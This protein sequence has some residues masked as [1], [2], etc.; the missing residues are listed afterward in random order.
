MRHAW[1]E[2]LCPDATVLHLDD[3]LPSEPHEHPDF[4]A[5]W[6][7]AI[8]RLV[9]AGPDV[10]VSSE[11]YGDELARRLGARHVCFDLSRTRVP[12]SATAVRKDPLGAWPYLP[13]PV[14]AYY[15]RRVAIYGPEST[16]KTTLAATLAERYATVWCPEFARAHLDLKGGPVEP[17]DIPLIA[18][19]QIA[20]EDRLARQA[21]RVLFCD[22]ELS[23]T[24][25]YAEHYFGACPGWLRVEAMAR[26]YALYLLL[27]VDVPWVPDP[28]RD[29]GHSRDEM[30]AR[31]RAALDARGARYEVISGSWDQRL[32]RACAAIDRLLG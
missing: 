13:P 11:T 26:R 27:D 30:F 14:R 31:F 10:V 24:V 25:I 3:E 20:A 23:T 17:A 19:G 32:S 8:R 15:A 18:Q 28:Q 9:P 16:G 12:I 1:L 4:W 5:L 7:A 21:N 22:T 6:I 2:E 29:L